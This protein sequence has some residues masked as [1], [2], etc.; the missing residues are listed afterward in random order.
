MNPIDDAVEK[1]V[2]TLTDRVLRALTNGDTATC[3]QIISDASRDG[4]LIFLVTRWALTIAAVQDGEQLITAASVPSASTASREVWGP[5]VI[6]LIEAAHAPVATRSAALERA[7]IA[8]ITLPIEDSWY[9]IWLLA[10]GV[11][12]IA[13]AVGS[14]DIWHDLTGQHVQHART[15]AEF[16]ICATAAAVVAAIANGRF[17]QGRDWIAHSISHFE[18]SLALLI[19]LWMVMATAVLKSD[20]TSGLVLAPNGTPQAF[21]NIDITKANEGQDGNL[22]IL[23]R[24]L[25]AVHTGN[26]PDAERAADEINTLTFEGRSTLCLQLAYTLA[27]GEPGRAARER[28]QNKRP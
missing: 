14:L 9:A 7:A 8:T 15:R 21:I 4:S 10:L 6:A 27:F 11:H 12:E 13:D 24:V 18:S 19:R 17:E 1:L 26:I 28:G 23:A 3:S 5:A 25:A 20:G 22:Q 2:D 16:E